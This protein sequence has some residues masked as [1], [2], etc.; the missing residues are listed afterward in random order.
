[1]AGKLEQ[2]LLGGRDSSAARDPVLMAHNPVDPRLAARYAERYPWLS[3]SIGNPAALMGIITSEQQR[4][5]RSSPGSGGDVYASES[6]KA[7]LRNLYGV[8][9]FTPKGFMEWSEQNKQWFSPKT[10]SGG[11]SEMA[12]P[13]R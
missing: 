1:M 2:M 11:D 10:S 5:S 12:P 7:V 6:A 8:N 13:Y 4:L 3:E 9:N